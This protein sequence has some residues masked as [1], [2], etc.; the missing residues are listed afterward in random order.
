M[1]QVDVCAIL[2]DVVKT[3]KPGTIIIVNLGELAT[4]DEGYSDADDAYDA[5]NNKNNPYWMFQQDEPYSPSGVGT[6]D[7]ILMD[8]INQ[9]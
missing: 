5:D 9:T 4:S 1:A 7:A 2:E 6:P 3:M 8:N